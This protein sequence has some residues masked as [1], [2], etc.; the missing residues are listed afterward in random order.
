MP[1]LGPAARRSPTTLKLVAKRS[2]RKARARAAQGTERLRS[3]DAQAS[4]RPSRSFWIGALVGAAVLVPLAVI[5]TLALQGGDDEPPAASAPA[6]TA[7]AGDEPEAGDETAGG[8]VSDPEDLR[9]Q[10]AARDKRQIEQLTSR[11]REMVEAFTP[12]VGGLGATLPP[13]SERVGPLA[14]ASEVE[15]WRR[16]VLEADAYFEE[17]VSGET[18]TNVARSGFANA[19]DVLLET[20]ETYKLALEQPNARAALLERARTQRDLAARTWSTAAIQLDVIN[21]DAGYGH[22]HVVFPP[23]A[24]GAA[25]APDTLPEGSDEGASGDR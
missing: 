24:G 18:A 13:D 6:E 11:T 3:S 9:K 12:V 7:V 10:F 16:A 2:V 25:V 8:V 5:A 15:D 14:S 19:V 4:S 1:P 23:S 17:T 22:Q 20:L 21:I